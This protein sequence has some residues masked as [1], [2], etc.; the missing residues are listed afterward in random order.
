MPDLVLFFH[1][2]KF[3]NACPAEPGYTLPLQCRET[4]L[5]SVKKPT[6]MNLHCLSLSM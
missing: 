4:D 2:E 1:I 3:L 5:C 6:D